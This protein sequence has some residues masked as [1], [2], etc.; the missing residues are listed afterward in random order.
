L[1]DSHLR[2]FAFSKQPWDLRE[3]NVLAQP[4][5]FRTLDVRTR[6]DWRKWL[7]DHHASELEVWLIYHK[8]HTGVP[9][10]DYMDSVDEALCFGW[11]DSLI[12]RIDEER[13][14]RKFTP[15]KPDSKWSTTNRKRYAELKAG[16]RLMRAGLDRPPTHRSGDAPRPSIAT[17]PP[18]IQEALGKNPAAWKFFQTLA[19]SYRRLY[20]AWIDSAKQ[21]ET[22]V[23][24]LQQATGLLAQGK[25]LGLK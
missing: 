10:V 19:P 5:A 22:K 14:A 6:E 25:K 8:Q 18:Y 2:T 11:I 13:Y 17:L 12:R 15:R 16:G 23:R 9:S 3:V 21:H 20:V 4:K 24:R 7:A 1:I